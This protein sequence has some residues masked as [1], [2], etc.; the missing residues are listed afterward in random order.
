MSA[1]TAVLLAVPVLV[2]ALT[3]RATG[4]GFGLVGGPLLVAAAGPVVGVSMANALSM[5]L[6]SVVLA[7]TW[8]DTDWRAVLTLAVPA[9][10][11]V[12]LGALVV[13]STPEGPL[14]IVV[15]SMAIL[16]VG[17]VVLTRQRRL[18]RGTPG[19]IVAGALSGFMNVTAGVGGPMVSAYALSE[20]WSRR[21]LIPTAQAYLL[22]V[23]AVSLVSKGV[24]PI[25]WF[26]WACGLGGLVVG[27]L[28]GE[29]LDRRIDA[30]TGRRLII[31]VALAGGIAAVVRGV[32]TT[33]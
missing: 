12:P 30:A 20:Q 16:A 17:V 31:V 26:G 29:W 1:A 22:L 33:A 7:R 11:G 14:L 9:L 24:P 15:G 13:R 27:A 21:V 5:V 8:R 3:Q 18:L 4:L 19:A 25:S 23:N 6:C 32:L 2:G 28:A 10:A